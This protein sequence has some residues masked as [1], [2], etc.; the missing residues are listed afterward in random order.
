MRNSYNFFY[1]L[2]GDSH[3]ELC[4]QEFVFVMYFLSDLELIVEKTVG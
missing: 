4:N 3:I 1:F 2:F